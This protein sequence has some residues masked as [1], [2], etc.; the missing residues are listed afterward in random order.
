MNR[1]EKNEKTRNRILTSAMEEFAAHGFEAASLNTICRAGE[2]SKGIIYHYFSSKDGLYLACLRTCFD[3]LTGYLAQ[4]IGTLGDTGQ[5]DLL[6]AYFQARISFF[7][8]HEA[9]ARIFCGAVMFPPPHLQE[10]ILEIRKSFDEM[11][12]AC[13]R[14]ILRGS[15]LRGDLS[16]EEIL[17]AFRMLQDCLNSSYRR[18]GQVQTDFARHEADCRNLLHIF[19][20][21]ILERGEKQA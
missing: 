4:Q 18:T 5:E 7:R 21:G 9:Y 10:K 20:Y 11:N 3:A 6:S 1:E 17:R 13:L 14:K 19:L 8:S 2:V 16:E 15:R 12:D